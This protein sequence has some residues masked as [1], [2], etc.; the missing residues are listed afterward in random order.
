MENCPPPPGRWKLWFIRHPVVDWVHFSTWRFLFGCRRENAPNLPEGPLIFVGNHG[1]HFDTFFV[2]EIFRRQ[3]R[4]D[5]SAVAWD[6]MAHI[7]FVRLVIY[8]FDATLVTSGKESLA[9]RQ[10]V[11]ALD[12]GRDLWVLSEGHRSDVLGSFHTGAAAASLMSGCAIVPFSLRGVQ[13]LFKDL[14]WPRR[15]CGDVSVRFHAPVFPK[16]YREQHADLRS[17]AQAMTNDVRDLV[18]SGIDYPA[19]TSAKA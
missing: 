2:H 15:I 9:L 17:A 6:Q 3:L 19:A 5:G 8:G 13:P 4:R 10:M 11:R 1:S 12:S 18:A 7:P 16:P 14:P